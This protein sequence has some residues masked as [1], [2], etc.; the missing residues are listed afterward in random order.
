[1]NHYFVTQV[2]HSK[3]K[4]YLRCDRVV[5][6]ADRQAKHKNL[7]VALAPQS[8]VQIGFLL[9]LPMIVEIG[10]ERGFRRALT[11]FIIMQL[12]LASVFFKF[13]QGTKTHYYGRTGCGFVML[14]AKFAENFRF[15]TCSHFVK[16]TE[17]MILHL[18]YQMF[19][20]SY[21]G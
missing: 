4:S 14:H 12:Q 17:P 13:S 8:F 2:K 19:G 21:R 9:A 1:M 10:L 16:G 3:H 18:V 5:N 6:Y 15:Y 7:Q 11:D 20:H